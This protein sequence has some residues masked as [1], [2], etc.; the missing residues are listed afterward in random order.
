M[1]ILAVIQLTVNVTVTCATKSTYLEDQ[2][3]KLSVPTV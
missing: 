3:R 2:R 1:D